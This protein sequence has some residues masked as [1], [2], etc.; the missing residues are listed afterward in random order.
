MCTFSGRNRSG[1]ASTGDIITSEHKMNSHASLHILE[2]ALCR[3]P[4]HCIKASSLQRA[5]PPQTGYS[6][7]AHY[8]ASLQS[9]PRPIDSENSCGD[10]N[11]AQTGKGLAFAVTM[12]VALP[13]T[14]RPA[15]ARRARITVR[16]SSGSPHAAPSGAAATC[17]PQRCAL[18]RTRRH[19]HT[20]YLSRSTLTP[21]L[22]RDT[23]L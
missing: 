15:P 22:Q 21:T 19:T 6:V 16:V 23:Q 13:D 4:G 2:R 5:A 11:A 7:T 10:A 18:L 9:T 17:R 3:R 12:R 1:A 20:L 8:I 14:L